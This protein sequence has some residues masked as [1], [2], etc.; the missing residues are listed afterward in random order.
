MQVFAKI[1]LILNIY[2]AYSDQ[3]VLVV[4]GL[5]HGCCHE[6]KDAANRF[7]TESQLMD[8]ERRSIFVHYVINYLN[9]TGPD[10]S[11]SFI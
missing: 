11:Q 10:K 2:V 4:S 7:C 8:I 1:F 3:V 6:R 5:L 9:N